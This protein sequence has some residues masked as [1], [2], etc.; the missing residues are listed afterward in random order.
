MEYVVGIDIGGTCTDC[1]V[2]TSKGGLSSSVRRS[3]AP[4]LLRGYH[5]C[6]RGGGERAGRSSRRA[7][8]AETKLFI[9]SA[10]V[11][12]N[13]VTDGNLSRVGLLTTRGFEDTLFMTRGGYGR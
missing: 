11:A 8:G 5:R 12:E 3:L 2:V 10:T 1:V 13:A 9:H 4:R 7:D 6:A